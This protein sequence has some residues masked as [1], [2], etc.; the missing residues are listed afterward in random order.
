MDWTPAPSQIPTTGPQTQQPPVRPRPASPAATG[1]QRVPATRDGPAADRDAG[2]S[3][4]KPPDLNTALERARDG[5]EEAFRALYRDAHPRVLRYL[6]AMVGTDAE[7]VASETWLQVARDLHAFHGDSD[8]FRGWVAT[9]ARH[10]ATDHLRGLRRRPQPARV[11]PE[12]LDG[13]AAGDDTEGTALEL[14]STDA[15]IALIARL[16]DD[17]AEAVLLRVVMGLDAATAGKVLGKR[18]GTVRTASYRGLR[19]LSA[20]LEQAENNGVAGLSAPPR[21]RWLGPAGRGGAR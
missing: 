11:L 13:W 7:D 3:W 2:A 14:L 4:D 18:P 21:E 17:Q 5:D 6:Q 19:R 15:A 1:G 9:I 20:W 12:D 8:G 16:P 10:R